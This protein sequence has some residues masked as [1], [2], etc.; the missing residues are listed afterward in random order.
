MGLQGVLLQIFSKPLGDRPTVF[1]EI[2]QRIGCISRMPDPVAPD[3]YKEVRNGCPLHAAVCMLCQSEPFHNYHGL[4]RLI[5][6]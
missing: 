3:A 6:V 5:I 1:V 4:Y 2:I